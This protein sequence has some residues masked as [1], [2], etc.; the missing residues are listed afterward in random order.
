MTYC[1]KSKNSGYFWL[2]YPYFLSYLYPTFCRTFLRPFDNQYIR[3]WRK[4][5]YLYATESVAMWFCQYRVEISQK[6]AD[7]KV[8]GSNPS[9]KPYIGTIYLD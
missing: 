8:G 5:H 3:E 1:E 6:G 4:Y 9:G 7:R 2:F